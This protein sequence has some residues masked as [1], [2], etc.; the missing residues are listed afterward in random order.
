M[1]PFTRYRKQHK[2]QMS[3]ADLGR[4]LGISRSYV[5]RIERGNRKLGLRFLKVA[6]RRTGLSP[7]ELRPD[8]RALWD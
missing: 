2:P 4:L 8:L 3:K 6:T 7:A 1:H 5:H